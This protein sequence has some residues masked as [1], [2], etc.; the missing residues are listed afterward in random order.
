[1]HAASDAK[2]P[3]QTL[4][5]ARGALALLV[6]INLFNYIDR[7]VLAA[8]EPRIRAEFFPPGSPGFETATTKTG[9]LATAFLVAY[10]VTAPIFGWLADRKPRWIIIGLGVTVWSIASG[11]SGLAQAYWVLLLMRVLIGVG[12]AAYGP[13]APTLIADMYPVERRGAVLSWFY[14]A[15]PV[16]SALGYILGGAVLKIPHATWHWAFWVTLPPGIILGVLCFLRKEPPRAHVTKQAA[17]RADY[18]TLLRTPSYVLAVAGLTAFT[19]VVGAISFWAPTYFSEHRHAAS[20]EGVSKI[21]GGI[22]V[23]AGLTATLAGGWLGDRL[24]GKVKGSYFAVSGVGVL[25]A[26]PLFL[27][28]LRAPFPLA[29]VCM[30]FT[31]FFLFLSTG[32][33]NTILAN[34]THP[35]VRATGFAANIFVIHALGDAISPPIVG[36]ITD[37]TKSA[38]HPGGNMTIAFLSL[39]VFILIAGV[40]WLMGA[41]HLDRD[42]ELAPSRIAPEN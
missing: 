23:V 30:F 29:W 10:F 24:R 37:A 17:T 7:Y 41:R 33:V 40:L 35:S 36:A 11:G 8:V 12:E 16:G 15:I 4:P 42:T 1:M 20:L 6:A 14:I 5:G 26:L 9:F 18:L 38:S 22:L 31:I 32:P 34:V 21:F 3:T 13:A 39:S 27:I 28:S 25:I 2:G 19:F